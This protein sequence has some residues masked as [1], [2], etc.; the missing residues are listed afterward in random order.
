MPLLSKI[1]TVCTVVVSAAIIVLSILQI[2]NVWA[3]A[4]YLYM[5][6]IGVNLLLQAYSQWKT[7]KGVAI[8]SL[9]AAGFVL[10][11][12]AVIWTLS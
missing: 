11:C 3:F 1:V 8:F 6:L 4:P 10:V 12:S 7:N 5:P 9:C 2:C